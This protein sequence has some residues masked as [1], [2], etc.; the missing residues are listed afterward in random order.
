MYTVTC[1]R[2]LQRA[3]LMGAKLPAVGEIILTQ[4]TAVVVAAAAA[5]L[6]QSIF[7]YTVHSRRRICA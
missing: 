7:S 5:A 4:D 3:F 2:G 1:R 6:L